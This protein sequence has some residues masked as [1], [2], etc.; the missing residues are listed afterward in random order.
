[1]V[2]QLLLCAGVALCLSA[3]AD[4]HQSA[5]K[6]QVVNNMEMKA[7][8]NLSKADM[9]PMSIND[10]S[11]SVSKSNK[12]ASL[13]VQ[14]KR[15]AGQFWGT[16]ICPEY[17]SSGFYYYNPL[18]LRPWMEYTFENVSNMATTPTW[19]VEYYDSSVG[20]YTTETTND[21]DLTISYIRYES[22]E[23]P[24]VSYKNLSYPEQY[25]NG[26][27]TDSQ[28]ICVLANNNIGDYF[29]ATML[30]SP[31]YYSLF[32]RSGESGSG[33]QAYYG[34]APYD[35]E[36]E[37]NGLWF[38]TNAG[39]YN[40]MAT[41][42]EKPDQPY[43]LNCVYFYY[44]YEG[45]FVNDI[46]VK[47]YV[48][49]TQNDAAVYEGTNSDGE[50][51]SIECV[52]LGDLI[53]VAEAVIPAAPAPDE[54]T[55]TALQFNFVEKN[56]V[57]G[58]ENNVSLEIEDDITIVVVG[59]NA[60][61]GPGASLTSYLSTDEF[62]EGYGNVGFLGQFNITDDGTVEYWLPA[63]K[64]F[65]SSELPN[66]NLG[67]LA[68][69]SYPWLVNYFTQQPSSVK[70][71]NDGDTTD[72][73]QGLQYYLYLMSTSETDDFEIT[74]DGE[75]DCDWLAV[76]DVYDDYDV[77]D[78][79]E[80]YFTGLVGLE[81][82]AEP[83]PNDETRVCNVKISI[84]AATYEIEFLQGSEAVSTSV[85]SVN[86]KAE[87][88]AQYFDLAGRRVLNPDKGIYVKVSGNKAE[89]VAL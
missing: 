50:P 33:L 23:A 5:P 74:Y 19:T 66:S 56:P 84:P 43:L 41:R 42:F 21:T 24:K 15:P 44:G 16:G 79:G 27:L 81:F 4:T 85:K 57:T 68:D 60:F 29:G 67:V 39:G 2:R 6:T 32:T 8:N 48:F 65:F 20:D 83:N 13:N 78:D 77:D 75:D 34:A 7:A 69:V 31:H 58:A 28:G 14:W 1:M 72:T 40:A 26:S 73:V 12:T 47:A 45:E 35:G 76:V 87:G 25:Y 80:E 88:D 55:N 82:D 71:A 46:P 10:G 18:V 62:D 89:K 70:F 37:T 22:P 36:D 49:K 86:V 17:V 54:Y 30:V 9:K 52:E 64:N 61:P 63:L 51:F 59:Y 3:M 38:G 11:N 53:A